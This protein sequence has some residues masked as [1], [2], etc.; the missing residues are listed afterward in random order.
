MYNIVYIMLK[1][2]AFPTETF[3]R[4]VYRVNVTHIYASQ[5]KSKNIFKML[6]FWELYTLKKKPPIFLYFMVVFL[7][8]HSE[9]TFS[10]SQCT[11]SETINKYS[12]SIPGWVLKN[13]LIIDLWCT[14]GLN[15]RCKVSCRDIV[16]IFSCLNE[17]Q[18]A[19]NTRYFWES[20]NRSLKMFF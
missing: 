14:K 15:K 4:L 20:K 3:I 11:K 13:F 2:Q 16:K 5:A 19:L 8:W 6:N 12:S 17:V 9:P 18:E 7:I 10:V 1:N